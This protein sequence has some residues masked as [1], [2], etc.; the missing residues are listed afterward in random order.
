MSQLI[1]LHIE[2]PLVAL[3]GGG[4]GIREST[5]ISF[6]VS[7]QNIMAVLTAGGAGMEEALLEDLQQVV[8]G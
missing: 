3:R 2:A 5:P 4:R 6:R 8:K 7:K 1:L